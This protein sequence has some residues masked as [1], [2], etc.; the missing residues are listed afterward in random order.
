VG[1]G[2]GE[3]VWGTFTENVVTVYG[4]SIMIQV[5]FQLTEREKE[6]VLKL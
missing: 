3:R 4:Q 5:Y 6:E 1:R 2:V